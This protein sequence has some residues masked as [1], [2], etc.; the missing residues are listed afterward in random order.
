MNFFK[1]LH[2]KLFPRQP[3][4]E[5]IAQRLRSGTPVV[6]VR[7]CGTSE[8]RYYTG[9]GNL[10][11]G[12]FFGPKRWNVH[13]EY[14]KWDGDACRL[15]DSMYVWIDPEELR[16]LERPDCLMVYNMENIEISK[17]SNDQL[18]ECFINIAKRLRP[19]QC[20]L[21]AGNFIRNDFIAPDGY[22]FYSG[23]FSDKHVIVP[24]KYLN[25]NTYS[26]GV[27]DLEEFD[28]ERVFVYDEEKIKRQH[29]K[30]ED[31]RRWY[32]IKE[33]KD[34]NGPWVFRFVDHR[35]GV[36]VIRHYG[37]E[38]TID[39]DSKAGHPFHIRDILEDAIE[40]VRKDNLKSRLHINEE[41]VL[42]TFQKKSTYLTAYRDL[43]AKYPAMA[44][45]HPVM[46]VQSFSRTHL[47]SDS[48]TSIL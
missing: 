23:R 18:R 11:S 47:I 17:F 27:N 38:L 29:R 35:T 10:C 34:A 20:Y 21:V 39:V 33:I 7:Y 4:Y 26:R 16:L 8:M 42:V 40:W 9:S 24:G 1:K 28:L 46:V 36:K 48:R 43:C 25:L 31:I 6:S 5:A 3:V 2:Q 45:T 19:G 44:N 15:S 37:I 22:R 13:V 30:H 14:E 32:E 12:G 41:N